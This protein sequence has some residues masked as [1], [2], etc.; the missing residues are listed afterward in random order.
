MQLFQK[1][2]MDPNQ[3]LHNPINVIQL[4]WNSESKKMLIKTSF[5]LVGRVPD[6]VRK[7]LDKVAK[8][9]NSKSKI[10]PNNTILKKFYGKWQDKLHI[11][12]KAK[13]GGSAFISGGSDLDDIIGDIDFSDIDKLDKKRKGTDEFDIF[14]PTDVTEVTSADITSVTSSNITSANASVEN[15]IMEKGETSMPIDP[16]VAVDRVDEEEGQLIEEENEYTINENDIFQSNVKKGKTFGSVDNIKFVYDIS[17]YPEDKVS[18]FK[19]KIYTA[20]GVRPFCQHLFY[21]G[22]M[23][24]ALSYKLIAD[25]VMPFDIR[26]IHEHE[27]NIEGIPIDQF[28]HSKRNILQVVARDTFTAMHTLDSQVF[29]MVDLD[30]FIKPHLSNLQKINSDKF[31]MDLFYYGFVIKYWPML[32]YE[33]WP[34][35]LTSSSQDF[36]NKYPELN[37]SQTTLANRYLAEYQLISKLATIDVSEIPKRN[38]RL[39]ITSVILNVDINQ[40]G[41]SRIKINIR[42][43][44]DKLVLNSNIPFIKALLY[45]DG[46]VILLDKSYKNQ[47]RK[48]KLTYINSIL[49]FVRIETNERVDSSLPRKSELDTRSGTSDTRSVSDSG[50]FII[51]Q[52]YSNGRY[53]IRTTW[54][55]ELEM[56]FEQIHKIVGRYITPVIKT[57][58]NMGHQVFSSEER[59]RMPEKHLIQ[60]TGLN[61]NIFWNHMISLGDFKELRD[62]TLDYTKAN[63][64]QSRPSTN[65]NTLDFYFNKGI[66]EFDVRNLLRTHDIQ[67]YYQYLTDSTVKQRWDYLFGNGRLMKIIHRTS[68][69]K[70]EIQGVR[71]IEYP[72][73]LNYILKMFHLMD[74]VFDVSKTRVREVKTE[75]KLSQLKEKDPEAYDFSRHNSNL[76]YS[77]L[78]QKKDQPN[79]YTN[80]E[81]K[82][83]DKKKQDSLFKYWNFTHEEPAYYEC[84]S[85]KR[86]YISFITGK[87]PK[88]YCLVC[89]KI[90]A[91][92]PNKVSNIN[93]K[94]A[95][96]FLA[97]QESHEYS[98]AKSATS[99]KSKYIM[100]YGK[101]IEYGRIGQLPDDTLATLF[102]D[103][104]ISFDA[105]EK[106]EYCNMV[107]Y[108]IYGVQQFTSTDIPVGGLFSVAFCLNITAEQ[109]I[110]DM[111]NTLKTQDVFGMIFGGQLFDYFTDSRDLIKYLSDLLNSKP[112][113][114]RIGPKSD[115]GL[116]LEDINKIIIDL[117]K[118]T[119]GIHILVFEDV[120]D[121]MDF[122]IPKGVRTAEEIIPQSHGIVKPIELARPNQFKSTDPI[123]STEMEKHEYLLLINKKATYYPICVVDPT[124]FFRDGTMQKKVYANTDG[125]IQRLR[126]MVTSFLERNENVEYYLTLGIISNFIR[127]INKNKQV[128][129][130][131]ISYTER[132]TIDKYFVNSQNMVYGLLIRDHKKN[133]L[134]IPVE[135]SAYSGIDT[136]NIVSVF[137]RGDYTLKLEILQEFLKEYNEYVLKESEAQ[138]MYTMD[139]IQSSKA[140]KAKM[141]M[142]DRVTP[143]YP[144]IIPEKWIKYKSDFIAFKSN[145]LSFYFNSYKASEVPKMTMSA[146]ETRVST[147]D[148]ISTIDDDPDH[149]NTLIQKHQPPAQDQRMKKAFQSQYNANIYQLVMIE[150]MNEFQKQKNTKIRKQLIGLIKRTNFKLN[151]NTFIKQFSEL[152]KDHED[153][154]E[155]IKT[156]INE[157]YNTHFDKMTLI[158]QINES[159]YKFDAYKLRDDTSIDKDDKNANEEIK[160]QLRTIANKFVKIGKLP[161]INA[162]FP[163][164]TTPCVF[165]ESGDSANYCQGNKI[166]IEES[167]LTEI[168]DIFSELI[169]DPE[170]E[171]YL[172]YKTF[173]QNTRNFFEFERRPN[174]DIE[175]SLHTF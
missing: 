81:F 118:L 132:Y 103:T 75:K 90:T 39:A 102:S 126:N 76:V 84:P 70:I 138:N 120:E 34:D 114:F 42:N 65:A 47:K 82:A 115:N 144:F 63:I 165:A 57:I 16:N 85:A 130:A 61:L 51:L 97:C 135:N 146:V 134:Y 64:L 107:N 23:T 43:L 161:S 37:P 171:R 7:E 26:L 19:E 45:K 121:D 83:L 108:Y 156:Q 77:R 8:L 48:Y 163:N 32:T 30:E 69:L 87:H 66:T 73:V 96:T 117:A 55:E 174:E 24:T 86:P 88:D 147:D 160:K 175:V 53:Q 123:L 168:I 89:C 27:E 58:N 29:Y 164:I 2:R 79:I 112:L 150:F 113:K 4:E 80:E 59:L 139:Y 6:P 49:I 14:D 13:S 20:L 172:S 21:E 158:A 46:Q 62:I 159:H 40:F 127:E 142:Q 98:S 149:I 25:S 153:D 104:L 3:Y 15:S 128:K 154:F 137:I 100:T 71:E 91:S 60:Y 33:A 119:Y 129:V 28:L 157:F 74:L 152:L 67:N 11:S 143:L 101:D 167:K 10:N 116:K 12:N 93:I 36:K 111:I 151:L 9:Y 122:V 72:I 173:V 52:L 133:L 169:K 5:V 35:Y 170:M 155:R 78:C 95:N 125:I 44:F 106:D 148:E 166:I 92:D 18:E 31:Q 141:P 99:N 22:D 94:K 56:D 105:L 110:K 140:D 136:N 41:A 50:K 68:D 17:V 145:R 54:G 109:V 162:K 38:Y 131:N 124:D 1:L